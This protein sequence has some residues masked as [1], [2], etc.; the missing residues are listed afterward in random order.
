VGG[1]LGVVLNGQGLVTAWDAATANV[2]DGKAFRHLIERFD[3]QSIVLVQL[4]GLHI[5]DDGKYHPSIA[6]FSL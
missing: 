4:N 5:G 3:G 2:Y 6:N 1:K